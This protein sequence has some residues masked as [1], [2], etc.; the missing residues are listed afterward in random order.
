MFKERTLE[1]LARARSFFERVLQHDPDN[2][3]AL[4][5]MAFV[6]FILATTFRP[7][8]LTS[9]LATAEAAATKALTL[10]PEN[11]RAHECLGSIFSATKRGEQAI[12]QCERALAINPN[13]A[14]A[15]ATIGW[16]KAITGRAEET[17]AHVQEAFRLSPR[18]TGASQWLFIVG[19]AKSLS[20]RHEEAVAW[21]RRSIE[22]NRTN[23]S[24]HFHLAASLA[25]MGRL[26]KARA[27]A[28]AGLAIDPAF[29]IARFQAFPFGDN[30]TYLAGRKLIVDGMRKAGL[31]EG[32]MKTN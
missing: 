4:V 20:G 19:G 7:D 28:T 2:V 18:D 25:L 22:A 6:D 13:L 14:N 5:P 26:E 32:A 21:F 10:A 9:R 12:A 1:N 3:G 23:P 8:D 17:E 31:P 30:P 27:A 29:T 16:S 15:H 11:A 24:V